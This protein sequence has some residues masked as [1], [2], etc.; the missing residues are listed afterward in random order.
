M[1][2][3]SRDKFDRFPRATT[4][5]TLCVLDRYG[6]LDHWPARPTLAPQIRFLY[7]W[8]ALLLHAS[9]RPHLTVT[10]LRFATLHLHQVG[11]GLSPVSCLHGVPSKKGRAPVPGLFIYGLASDIS[12]SVADFTA[13]A[14]GTSADAL[15]P[16]R[17]R[18]RKN[19]RSCKRL[20]SSSASGP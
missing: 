8:L 12:E 13:T 9:F 6:L 4:R 18:S 5:F 14:P 1:Q 16:W 7:I 19:R 11:T 3:L 20:T 15:S 10:P 17:A 2:Q